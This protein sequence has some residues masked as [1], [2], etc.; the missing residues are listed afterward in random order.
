M[1]ENLRITAP[2]PNSDGILKPNP[3]AQSSPVEPMEP[4][5]VNRPDTQDQNADSASLNLLLGRDSVF[6]KFI[7]QFRQT[8]ALSETLGKLLFTTAR[9]M[10]ASPG[11][12]QENSVLKDLAS[13]LKAE[14]EGLLENLMFQQKSGSL[15]SGPLFRLLDHISE[16][17]GD[18]QID[19][20]IA[21]FLK[22]FDGYS[23]VGETTDAI[24]SNLD[25]IRQ[26]IPPGEAEQ[27]ALLSKKLDSSDPAGSLDGNLNLLKKE[28]LPF[29]S[30]YVSKSSDYGKVRE[31]ISLLLQNLS[32]LNVS[33]R[34]NLEAQFRQL[35]SYCERRVT[36]PTLRLMRSFYEEAAG[37]ETK[38]PENRF[39]ESLISLL[40]QNG[41]PDAPEAD[42]A[43]CADIGRSLLLDN[44]VYMPFTHIFLPAVLDGRFLFA[45]IWVEKKES[46][47]EKSASAG[48]AAAP[49]R[50]YLTFTIQDLGYFEARMELT[51]KKVDLALSC[52]E[53]LLA[54][55]SAIVSSLGQILVNNGL[56]SGNIRLSRCEKPEV[57]NLILQKIM[58]RKRMVD[59]TV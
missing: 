15:F 28:I 14:Q 46:R 10:E 25:A 16:Q 22:A 8:P 45:Q 54:Q 52:P 44:S 49:T 9:R 38:K 31:T 35:N 33:S 4:A 13:G 19:L 40:S 37:G 41:G 18:P 42:K 1:P 6:G 27:L 34:E 43:L 21:A 58:E 26:Q 3:S 39:F 29:L 2:V 56:S 59:V 53:K 11:S 36:E 5:R 48:L 30:A 32:I 57:P 7:G 23:S 17:A 24:L 47:E 51:G 12:L 55:K 50:L 20:R